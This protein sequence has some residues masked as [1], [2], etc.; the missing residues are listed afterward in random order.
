MPFRCP[1]CQHE[2]PPRI[3]KQ[4]STAGWVVFVVLL[5]FCLPLFWIGLLIKEDKRICAGCGTP[6]G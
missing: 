3:E 2:G 5:I 1:Y 6:L 4:I